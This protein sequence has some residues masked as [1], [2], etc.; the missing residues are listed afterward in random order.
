MA[1]FVKSKFWVV[2]PYEIIRHLCK[3]MMAPAAVKD[4]R[5][6]KPRLLCDHSWP[7]LG[8]PSVNKTTVPHA[9]PEAMQFGCALPRMILWLL[10][11]ANPKFGPARLAKYDVK[12]GFY[13]LFLRAL[14][15]LCLALIPP[16][17][18][19][20][21]QLVAIPLACTMGWVQSP[22]TFCTMSKTVCNLANHT[23]QSSKPAEAEHC[24]ETQASVNDDLSYSWEPHDKEPE[25]EEADKALEP[26]SGGVLPP[27]ETKAPAPPSNMTFEKPVGTTDVFMDD[28]IQVGQGGP[29]RMQK[30]CRHLLE[31]VDQ[32]L[33]QPGEELHQNK[34]ITLKKLQTGDG[35]WTTR[36][37]VLGWVRTPSVAQTMELPS[38]WKLLLA[39]IF[40]HLQGWKRINQKTWER[41]LGQLCF[42]SVA[43]P[44]SAGL[45]STLQLELTQAKG[46]QVRINKSLQHHIVTFASLAASLHNRPTHLAEVVPQA[47]SFMGTTDA[48]KVGMGGVYFDASGQ[49]YVWRYPFP[50]DIQSQLVS[51]AIPSGR[52][53]N[54]NL[55][56]AGLLAQVAVI[57]HYQDVACATIVNRS[58]NTP[59]VSPITKG[60]VTSDGPAAQLC[61]YACAH[62]HQHCYCHVPHFLPGD[63]SVVANDASRLQH[64]TNS[65]FLAHF[66]Q[67]YPQPEPWRLLRLPKQ[68]RFAADLHT[69]L[70]TA[71][72]ATTT[73]C[74]NASRKIFGVWTDFCAG[75]GKPST[76][77]TMLAEDILCYL[78]VFRLRYCKGGQK[79]KPV[80][81]GTLC[82]AMSAVAKGFTDLDCPDPRVNSKT[83]NLHSVL[84]DFY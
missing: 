19:G 34:A 54:S 74:R 45:F 39:K 26:Y 12:D 4:E 63:A 75:E 3:L 30:L 55:E 17:Y 38:H 18:E 78:L 70:G 71:S 60:A 9:P 52:V 50:K 42:V 76:L 11:H 32:F 2:L 79:G 37:V 24:L 35:S 83:G 44:G 36:K 27:A 1:E 25:Q 41:Y 47:H 57:S 15:C 77:H 31:A 40:Q 29:K 67:E 46:N 62:Q 66:Q 68:K 10:R 8:W 22:P 14:E 53:T 5:E 21:T 72:T 82:D 16:K 48:A 7:W 20:E 73:K 84:T 28:Y 49:G 33:A 51:K 59:A 58:D 69:A 6:R 81:A 61:N 23:I 80:Q 13:R 56:Q 43:I 65:A 64:L